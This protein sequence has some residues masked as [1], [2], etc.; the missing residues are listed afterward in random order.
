[1]M[2]RFRSLPD[3]NFDILLQIMSLLTTQ[4][5]ACLTRTCRVLR[6]ALSS[7]LPRGEVTLEGRHLTSFLTF[8]NVKDG[9]DRL[10]YLHKLV[11]PGSTYDESLSSGEQAMSM[12]DVNRAVSGILKLTTSNLESLSILDLD[13]FSFRPVELKKMLDSLLRLRELEMSGIDQKYKNALVDTLPHL[14]KLTLAFLEDETDASPFLKAPRSDLQAVTLYNGTLKDAT[15]SFPTVHTLRACPAKLPSDVDAY[16]RIFPNVRD[17]AL[18]FP[19]DYV[20]MDAEFRKSMR[21]YQ[22]GMAWS[23]P[24]VQEWRARLLSRPQM[25]A[26]AWPHLQSLRTTGY[27][28][29][30]LGWAGLTRQVARVEMSCWQ[31]Q[32]MHQQLAGVL[33]EL[34]PRCV[35]FHPTSF[36]WPYTS[37][38]FRWPQLVALQ[39]APFVTRLA[40]VFCWAVGRGFVSKQVWPVRHDHSGAEREMAR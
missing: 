13:A 30:N 21:S 23:D 9:N 34:R 39:D 36:D 10:S 2:G 12:K 5:V 14:R 11:L 22:P 26:D 28:G 33:N 19:R 3:L 15:M 20:R 25:A 16:T 4:D 37:R 6:V 29:W 31:W 38:M 35:V 17:V 18:D 1:M 8:A 27:G 24:H 32:W 40:L 7:E